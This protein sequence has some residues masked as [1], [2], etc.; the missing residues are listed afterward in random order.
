MTQKA[1]L[2]T[3][4]DIRSILTLLET[5][6]DR[7]LFALGLYAGL[8]V[9]EIIELT[10]AAVFIE[11]DC[12]RETLMVTRLRGKTPRVSE[13]PIHP[14]LKEILREHRKTLSAGPWLI[15]SRWE[16][17]QHISRMQAHK[18]LS[19]A[20]RALKRFDARTHSMRRTFLVTL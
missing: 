17:Q 4:V 10:Q 1:R 2:L 12:V 6:R 20:F 14:K 3:A 8:R 16:P 19:A 18:I 15:P 5:P 11:T 13:I 7:A 9:S